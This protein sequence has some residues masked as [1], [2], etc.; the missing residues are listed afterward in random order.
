MRATLTRTGTASP[1][2]TITAPTISTPWISFS[3]NDYDADGC[4]D[5]GAD[6]DDDDDAVLDV[7]D[8][9]PMG[10]K[11]GAMRQRPLT[12]T[13]MDVMTTSKTTMMTRTASKTRLTDVHEASSVQHRLDKTTTATGASM[14]LKMM[15]T[16]KTVSSTRL[17]GV[18]TRTLP[19]Q[20]SSNGCSQ[21]Q[22][23]DDNDGVVNAYDFCLDSPL[24][25]VVDERGCHRYFDSIR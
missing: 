4:L 11:T 20:V 9:C 14:R 19:E 18:Q 25:A 1:F 5:E 23:D 2:P 8:A 21:Y 16:T 22:L 3:W 6:D 24:N 7:N 15:M 10:E 17:T 13:A 12:M